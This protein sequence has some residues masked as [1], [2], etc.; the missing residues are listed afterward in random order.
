MKKITTLVLAAA[1]SS[2]T[3]FAEGGNNHKMGLVLALPHPMKAIIPKYDAYDFTKEQ[4]EKMQAIIADMPAKM[5]AMFDEAEEI[6][7]E[8]QK[9]VMKEGQTKKQ[10]ASKLDKLQALKREITSLHIDTV[11]EIRAFMS[12]KQY[13]MMMHSL[14]E[15][16][17]QKHKHQH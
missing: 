9:A 7:R 14:K 10:L 8:I 5:H 3:L 1:L 17:E 4:D 2:A 16:Q 15:L 13:K 12:K 6:E 11:N